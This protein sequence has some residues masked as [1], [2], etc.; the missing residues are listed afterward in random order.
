LATGR[1][2]GVAAFFF[3][4]DF[5]GGCMSLKALAFSRVASQRQ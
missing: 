5:F 4:V 1:I 2:F 3:G